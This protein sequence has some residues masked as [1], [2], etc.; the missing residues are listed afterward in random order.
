MGQW[1]NQGK[2]EKLVREFVRE[3]GFLHQ[4]LDIKL[5]FPEEVYLKSNG[6]SANMEWVAQTIKSEKSEWDIV[7]INNESGT[8]KYTRDEPDWAKK[9]LVDFSQYPEFKKNTLPELLSDSVKNIWHGII[10]GPFIEGYNYALWCNLNVARKVGIEV[11][12]FDMTY[13]NL[14]SY[15]KAVYEY[16]LKNKNDQIA[17]FF[18]AGDWRTLDNIAHILFLSALSDD[19]EYLSDRVSERKLDAWHKTLQSIEELSKYKPLCAQWDTMSWNNNRYRILD[20]Q[21]LFF[22]NGSWMYNWWQAYDP[23]KAKIIILADIKL[24]GLFPRMLRIKKKR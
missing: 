10:P 15:V 7:T 19:K 8:C 5:Q 13:D 6:S 2:R 1:K 14:L 3:Y 18:E 23:Q 9:Y 24:P 12:Q 4:N 22:A 11:K 21:F 20:D 17:P 16:N